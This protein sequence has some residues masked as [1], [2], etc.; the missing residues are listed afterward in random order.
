MADVKA[1]KFLP[2]LGLGSIVGQTGAVWQE[3]IRGVNGRRAGKRRGSREERLDRL[4]TINAM[5]TRVGA[6][7]CLI[8]GD[9]QG[10]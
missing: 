1:L 9:A 10:V 8:V 7:E 5:R 6:G 4:A 3:G 2:L